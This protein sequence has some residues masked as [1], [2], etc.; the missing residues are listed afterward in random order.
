MFSHIVYSIGPRCILKF[1]NVQT[2]M[3]RYQIYSQDVNRAFA[4]VYEQYIERFETLQ[5]GVS[6]SLT[7]IGTHFILGRN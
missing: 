7:Y 5:V 2:H 4:I 1:K 6:T 3:V